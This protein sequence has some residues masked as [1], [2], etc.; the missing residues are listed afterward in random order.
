MDIRQ[1][2]VSAPF[3]RGE[4]QSETVRSDGSNVCYD[5]TNNVL[6]GDIY[7]RKQKRATDGELVSQ[8]LVAASNSKYD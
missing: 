4:G 2:K 8:I 3:R 7:D 5:D 1:G 6:W